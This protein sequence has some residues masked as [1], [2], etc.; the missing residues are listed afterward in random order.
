MGYIDDT[1]HHF[2]N[3]LGIKSNSQLDAEESRSTYLRNQGKPRLPDP[4]SLR[5]P[6]NAAQP[7]VRQG[8]DVYFDPIQ[9]QPQDGNAGE[10]YPSPAGGSM[11][12]VHL[13]TVNMQA[14]DQMGPPSDLANP[15]EIHPQELLVGLA[16]AEGRIPGAKVP[17]YE[18]GENADS[19]VYV[20]GHT[21][22]MMSPQQ[23]QEYLDFI[24]P[25]VDD[26]ADM[27]AP[28]IMAMRRRR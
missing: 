9:M 20:S 21:G 14:A 6:F 7:V 28:A 16:A 13:P 1:L 26:M 11:P 15:P 27:P 18:P 19:D 23:A 12:L 24:S 5:S 4:A 8:N 3:A 2:I 10:S 17:R 25:G 22:Q